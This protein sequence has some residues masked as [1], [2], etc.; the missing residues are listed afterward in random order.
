[1]FVALK[2]KKKAAS[3]FGFSVSDVK[4]VFLNCKGCR[5]LVQAAWL[6]FSKSSFLHLLMMGFKGTF[7]C[8]S[9]PKGDWINR[10]LPHDILLKY[11]ESFGCDMSK[12]GQHQRMRGSFLSLQICSQ[13]FLFFSVCSAGGKCERHSHSWQGRASWAAVTPVAVSMVH[14]SIHLLTD[15]VG[16]GVECGTSNGSSSV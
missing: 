10:Y 4:N 9:K 11:V 1:M 3:I 12:C 2:K 15:G 7:G 16:Q 8:K 5:A 13:A 14:R 6:Y